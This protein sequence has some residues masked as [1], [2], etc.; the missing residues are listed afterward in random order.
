MLKP[1]ILTPK[2][3]KQDQREFNSQG[4]YSC[5]WCEGVYM[6]QQQERI[7]GQQKYIFLQF[8]EEDMTKENLEFCF[9]N[10]L[11]RDDES[12][13]KMRKKFVKERKKWL[14]CI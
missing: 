3:S 8:L 9:K 11:S 13:K 12:I 6:F 14:E 4:F 1:S 10:N 5:G 2:I 7:N